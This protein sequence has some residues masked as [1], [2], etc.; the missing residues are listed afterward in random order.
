MTDSYFSEVA[1]SSNDYVYVDSSKRRVTQWPLAISWPTGSGATDPN[2]LLNDNEAEYFVYS[3]GINTTAVFV[4]RIERIGSISL[5]VLSGSGIRVAVMVGEALNDSEPNFYG[6]PYTTSG[7]S[8]R[9]ELY[10][11]TLYSTLPESYTDLMIPLAGSGQFNLVLPKPVVNKSFTVI[12][13]GEGSYSISQILPRKATG[14]FDLEVSAIKAYH[15]SADLIETIALQVSDSIVVSPDIPDK[16][17]TG[18]K[19]LDGTISGVIITPGTITSNEIAAG[20]ITGSRISAN[21]ISGALITAGTITSDKLQVDQLDAIA[22]NM[23]TLVVNSGISIGDNGKLYVGSGEYTVLNASGLAF[24]N[25]VS[26]AGPNT[27]PAS[28]DFTIGNVQQYAPDVNSIKFSPYFYDASGILYD[29]NPPRY[30]TII[31]QRQYK[32][33]NLSL[34]EAGNYST[35]SIDAGWTPSESAKEYY[36]P[37]EKSNVYFASKSR[38][39][40][41]MLLSTSTASASGFISMRNND[42]TIS[43]TGTGRLLKLAMPTTV[44]SAS[45]VVLKETPTTPGFPPLETYLQ[46]VTATDCKFD[47]TVS[48]DKNVYVR[49]HNVDYAAGTGGVVMPWNTLVYEHETNDNFL[50]SAGTPQLIGINKPGVYIFDIVFQA[51]SVVN[52]VQLYVNSVAT[53]RMSNYYGSGNNWR[54]TAMRYFADTGY[55]YVEFVLLPASSTTVRANGY[56]VTAEGPILTI[57]KVA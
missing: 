19:I 25:P 16:S 36:V 45:F 53:G 4:N 21:T 27:F 20:S 10:F 22:A 14:A 56:G 5:N 34:D 29:Y 39:I 32:E 23:G 37:T 48:H 41:T 11:P 7:T 1:Q 15:V 46:E 44:T 2:V 28:S 47:V 55:R 50:F 33:L 52:G 12:H 51:G 57:T 8:A 6:A 26:N 31:S 18:A 24:K 30:S 49:R 35:F 38:A 54:H 40:S 13:S 43:G 9:T 3:G 17:I 42:I